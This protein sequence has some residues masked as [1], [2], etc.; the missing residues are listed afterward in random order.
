MKFFLFRRPRRQVKWETCLIAFDICILPW[1]RLEGV[2]VISVGGQLFRSSTVGETRTLFSL[3]G[4]STGPS[5]P[6]V[7]LRDVC[8]RD[9]GWSCSYL[10]WEMLFKPLMSVSSLAFHWPRAVETL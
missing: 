1:K 7:L 5:F 2:G 10:E 3:Y 8:G 9:P 6:H 4:R